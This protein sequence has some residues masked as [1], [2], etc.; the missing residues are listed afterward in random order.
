MSNSLL[1]GDEEGRR[2]E[3][4]KGNSVPEKYGYKRHFIVNKAGNAG[5]VLRGSPDV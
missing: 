2:K 4:G 5:G 3:E 1:L